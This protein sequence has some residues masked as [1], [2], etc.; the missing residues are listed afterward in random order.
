MSQSGIPGLQEENLQGSWV[1]L[2]F[3][4]GSNGSGVPASV[5]L[6]NGD[7]EKILLDAQHESGRSSSKSSH[8]DR[9]ARRPDS[10]CADEVCGHHHECPRA[11]A[12]PG[13]GVASQL[14][15]RRAP[16]PGG[17]NDW[18][19]CG[20]GPFISALPPWLACQAA[21]PHTAS[22]SWPSG[23]PEVLLGAVSQNTGPG[24]CAP[25]KTARLVPVEPSC[26]D[27]MVRPVWCRVEGGPRAGGS[28]ATC[29]LPSPLPSPPRSQTPQDN[30]RASEADS[31]SVGEKNSVQVSRSGCP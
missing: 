11:T 4:H 29:L 14:T 25:P 15:G 19:W 1:E 20:Q 17:G 10:P 31:H 2:H 27:G 5:C 12:G 9:W 13:A 21:A 7:L 24:T 8:C 3:S 18:A 22:E 16:C 23:C 26:E 6:Y 30:N 28:R